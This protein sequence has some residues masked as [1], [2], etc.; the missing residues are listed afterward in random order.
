MRWEML[1]GSNFN[2]HTIKKTWKNVIGNEIL[3]LGLIMGNEIIKLGL[4][5]G[6]K[7]QNEN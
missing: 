6:N 7:I 5:M 3:K 1:G 4:I 2:A